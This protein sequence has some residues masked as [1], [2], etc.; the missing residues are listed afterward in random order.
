ME[1]SVNIRD[2]M[3]KDSRMMQFLAARRTEEASVLMP[4][5]V[6]NASE[7]S[8]TPSENRFCADCYAD[9]EDYVTADAE[10]SSVHNVMM[11]AQSGSFLFFF[12]GNLSA[13]NFGMRCE[14]SL[15]GQGWCTCLVQQ[16]LTAVQSDRRHCA[17]TTQSHSS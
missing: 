11:S 15:K 12:L 9:Q 10:P 16:E 6:C 13:L 8:G 2:M 3:E 1:F 7:G 14:S 5:G 17:C 4:H